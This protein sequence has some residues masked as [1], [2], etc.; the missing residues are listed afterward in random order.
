MSMLNGFFFSSF[1]CF[2][3]ERK[4]KMQKKKKKGN[5]DR[6]LLLMMKKNIVRY[7]HMYLSTFKNEL[8]MKN[9]VTTY[10]KIQRFM[11]DTFFHSVSFSFFVY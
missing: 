1:S 3:M 4:K 5:R 6:F 8:K 9:Y 7:M 2:L 11:I 10:F